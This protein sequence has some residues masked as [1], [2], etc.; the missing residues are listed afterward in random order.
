MPI[1]STS[2][3]KGVPILV[4]A[5]CAVV[6]AFPWVLPGATPEEI[7]QKVGIYVWGRVPDLVAACSD[8]KR[9]GADQVIRTFIGPWSDTPPYKDDL[10]PLREKA[11]SSE[12]QTI[13]DNYQV[14]MLTAYDSVSYAKVHVPSSISDQAKINE[15]LESA[16]PNHPPDPSFKVVR[17]LASMA[18]TEARRFLD[19]IRKEFRDFSAELSKVDRTFI[20]S[21]W[22]AEHDVPDSQYWPWYARYLQ[23]RI[24]GIVEGR[25]RA[26]QAGY[27]ARVFTAFEFTIIP[28]FRG[29]PSGL[30][31][32]GSKLRGVDYLSYSSWWSI[33][34]DLDAEAM[35]NSFRY[36]IQLIRS[37]AKQAGLPQRL[38]IGEFGE[39]WNMHPSIDRLKAIVDVSLEEGAEYLFNWVLYEQPRKRDEWGRDASH[40]GKFFLDRSLTPQ[41]E[42]FQRWFPKAGSDSCVPV[43]RSKFPNAAAFP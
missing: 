8:A 12:Y 37:F 11:I 6:L 38:I 1:G 34:W 36:A 10:R 32:I 26:R 15:S 19:E 27:P 22:E 40:F 24:H 31:D 28:G 43:A 17:D 18:P 13:F 21:N 2:K 9:L 39:Y 35:D 25:E 4:V 16:V 3:A 5:V 14:I 33:G 41:G 20:V 29:K 23:A 30:V 7:R 42:A